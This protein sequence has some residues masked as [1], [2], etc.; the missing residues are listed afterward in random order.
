MATLKLVILP[1]LKKENGECHIYVQITHRRKSDR[2]K[3]KIFV[4]PDNFK[5]SK[6]IGGKFGDKN[7]SLKNIRLAEEMT[8]YER[9]LLD[10]QSKIEYLD[11]KGIKAFLENGPEIFITDFFKFTEARLEELK[12]SGNKGTY[13]PLR[14]SLKLVREYHGKTTL[15][16]S[17]ITPRFLEGFKAFYLK[18]HHKIN[19]IAV[20]MRYIRSMFNDAIDEYNTNAAA[21]VI[22]N[23]PFRKY[24]IETEATKNRNLHIDIIRKIRDFKFESKREEIT[25]DIFMLQ[26][27]LDGINIIDLF[28][29]KTIN[30]GRIEFNRSK[31][32][33]YHNIK[34]EPEA[35]IIIDKYKGKK[36]LLWFADNCKAERTGQ[37][38]AHARIKDLNWLDSGSFNK[39]LNENLQEIQKR[40]KLKLQVHLT[41]YFAR[42]SLASIMREIG[43]SKDDISLCLGH[44]SVERNLKTTGGYIFED[45][46]PVD[47]ANRELIDFVNSEFKDGE[48]WKEHKKIP[49]LILQKGDSDVSN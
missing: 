39:M 3:T 38:T 37:R 44:K 11:V 1:K 48:S 36:Y 21:P 23:Y 45:F 42:H 14:N 5:G 43:V 12:T 40:L 22:L 41:T 16:F 47:I 4:L 35:Q 24:K 13:I 8:K 17:E 31:T 2:I 20:Y 18:L 26:L 25:K 49:P 46:K 32:G 7:A 15:N 29:L 19:S 10:N 9:I 27:Y 30:Q 33:R 34:V 6:V 28:S